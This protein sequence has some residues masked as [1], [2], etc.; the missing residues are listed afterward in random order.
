MH[1]EVDGIDQSCVSFPVS[2]LANF[3][4]RKSTKSSILSWRK[5]SSANGKVISRYPPLMVRS[6]P[7]V[8]FFLGGGGR[9]KNCLHMLP[10]KY[11]TQRRLSIQGYDVES[12]FWTVQQ[13]SLISC[14]A[15]SRDSLK[16]SLKAPRPFALCRQVQPRADAPT[17][18]TRTSTILFINFSSPPMLA[19]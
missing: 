9:D 12:C 17:I 5:T 11:Q 8:C 18:E 10:V 16:I 15:E 6:Y 13:K 7:F 19:F 1:F 2:V 4:Y 3:T 14:S